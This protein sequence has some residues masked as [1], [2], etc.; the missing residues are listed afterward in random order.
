MRRYFFEILA[1]A[2]IAG[3]LFFFKET[4]DYLARRDYVAALLVM[5]IGVAVI[6]VGKEM[7]RLALVQ[8]D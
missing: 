5:I 4:L 1:T 3:S 6:S 2:L 8:R 7:A